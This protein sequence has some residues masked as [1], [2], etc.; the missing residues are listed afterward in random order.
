MLQLELSKWLPEVVV[1]GESG[2]L[3]EPDDLDGMADSAIGL[4]GDH[5]R[6]C[7]AREAARTRAAVFSTDRIVPQYEALYREV[8]DG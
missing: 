7:A 6:W 2:M 5:Q 1:H 4:L 8:V 3:H